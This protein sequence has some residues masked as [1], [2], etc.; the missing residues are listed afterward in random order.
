MYDKEVVD[1]YVEENGDRGTEGEGEVDGL[2]SQV[3]PQ[4]V[5][6]R[7]SQKVRDGVEKIGLS[8]DRDG[9]VL[10]AEQQDGLPNP[11]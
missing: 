4:W 3:D 5:K 10:A 9:L 1:R 7:L 6:Q 11:I 2:A 8:L